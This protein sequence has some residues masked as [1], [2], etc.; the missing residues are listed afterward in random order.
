MAT[1]CPVRDQGPGPGTCP[2]WTRAIP[3]K[4]RAG[5]S[6]DSSQLRTT[7]VGGTATSG[8]LSLKADDHPAL[9]SNAS[10]RTGEHPTNSGSNAC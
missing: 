10:K 3:G 4:V 5:D 9:S 8:L 1:D 2:D 7:T 6:N